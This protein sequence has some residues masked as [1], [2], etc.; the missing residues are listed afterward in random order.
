[1]LSGRFAPSR[2]APQESMLLSL[3]KMMQG[4]GLSFY[5]KS[6]GGKDYDRWKENII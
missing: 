4:Q 2:V 1:M 3:Q 5:D 6:D